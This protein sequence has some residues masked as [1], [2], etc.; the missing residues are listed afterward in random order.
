VKQAILPAGS[1]HV[2]HE[3][4]EIVPPHS[5]VVESSDDSKPITHPKSTINPRLWDS[6][7][8]VDDIPADLADYVLG[9]SLGV[10][11]IIIQFVFRRFVTRRS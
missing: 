2:A 6:K 10:V 8:V 3:A 9:A 5:S 4:Q 7:N 11:V 1:E